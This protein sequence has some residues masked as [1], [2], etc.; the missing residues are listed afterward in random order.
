MSRALPA[1]CRGPART[2]LFGAFL[3]SVGV[4]LVVPYLAIYLRDAAAL[5]AATVGLLL[6]LNY[7]STRVFGMAA[8][9]VA[10]RWGMRRTMVAGNL[11]RAVG[12]LLLLGDS[13]AR[14]TCAVLLIG[15]GAG[16]YFP[17]AKAC[18]LH[19]VDDEHQLE[20]IAARNMCANAGVA[21][22]PL[23]G[24]LVFVHGPAGLFILAAAAFGVLNILLLP[25]RLPPNAGR[26]ETAPA[27]WRGTAALA[28]RRPVVLV[29][30]AT[31]LLGLAIVQLDSTFPLLVSR[32]PSTW[33]AGALF[34]INAL[35][36]IVVQQ[37]VAKVVATMGDRTSFGIG[38]ALFAASFALLSVPESLW[39]LWL[40][41][42]GVFSVAEVSVSLSIDNRVRTQGADQATTIYGLAGIGDAFGGLAGAMLG[43][44]LAGTAQAS[45]GWSD[46]WVLAPM[47]LIAVLVASPLLSPTL[48][49]EQRDT[50]DH[51]RP[52]ESTKGDARQ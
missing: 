32:G 34:L 4:F 23:I 11:L 31:T 25:L 5:A 1:W 39:V 3:S 12:Y 49:T 18:L 29:I 20:A 42:V 46:Y 10:H 15:A 21:L 17:V 30:V 41:A 6:G 13:P 52:R 48:R 26:T 14:V 47:V 27:Y 19:V 43:A 8:G 22:G 50:A 38:F 36:V 33:L 24:M 44:S 7:W 51:H 9:A 28:V 2:L 45:A 37:P 40:V 16:V 35:L